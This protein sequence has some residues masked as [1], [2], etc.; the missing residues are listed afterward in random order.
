MEAAFLT[1]TSY[2]A[3]QSG[4]FPKAV[5]FGKRALALSAQAQTFR[6]AWPRP[7]TPWPSP[8]PYRLGQPGWTRPSNPC[9]LQELGLEKAVTQS[10]NLIGVVYHNSGQYAQ[11][12]DAGDP[13]AHRAAPGQPS[14]PP[15]STSASPVPLGRLEEALQNHFGRPRPFPEIR[16]DESY[17][18]TTRMNLGMTYSELRRFDRTREHLR[19]PGPSTTSSTTATA[20]SRS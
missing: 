3:G 2:C 18:P 13:Q 7:T 17:W 16:D 14:S 1:S 12:I 10:L 4:D 20:S 15:G 19:W 6:S 8:T 9:A 11:A 5:D